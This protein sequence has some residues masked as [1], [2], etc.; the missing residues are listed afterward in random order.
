MKW[1]LGLDSNIPNYIVEE[2]CKYERMRIKALRRALKFEEKIR[3]S[4]IK[5]VKECIREKD[6]DR[7]REKVGKE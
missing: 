1:T 7:E 5:L 2:E 4:D 6:R 3:D